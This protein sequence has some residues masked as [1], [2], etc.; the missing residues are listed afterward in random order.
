MGAGV[1]GKLSILHRVKG[2]FYQVMLNRHPVYYFGQDK[3]R[4]GSV[5]G[6]GITSFGGR[7]HVV[8]ASS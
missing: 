2:G 5:K 8:P 6:Q 7:W 3:G 1:P 4:S